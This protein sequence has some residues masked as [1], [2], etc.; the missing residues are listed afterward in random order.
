MLQCEFCAYYKVLQSS[1]DRPNQNTAFCEFA[2]LIFM[3]DVKNIDLEYP[4]QNVSYSD[5]L[6]RSKVLVKQNI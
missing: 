3:N 1:E 5:Y 6:N 2:G 4:C